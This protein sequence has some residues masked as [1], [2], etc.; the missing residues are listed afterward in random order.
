MTLDELVAMNAGWIL[1]KARSFYHDD[2]NAEDL[3]GETIYRLLRVRDRYDDRLPFRP[4][5]VRI[6][7]N[8]FITDYKRQAVSPI[9]RYE[10][11]DSICGWTEA[12]F[13]A[14]F[15][16]TLGILRRCAAKSVNIEC[17]MLYAKGYTYDEISEMY[18]ISIGTVKSRISNGRTMIRTALG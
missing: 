10:D 15:R 17:V 2:A 11:A 16:S 18:G 7:T 6:M 1:S 3:A 12:D 9:D 4:F 8:L 14:V 5:A 13:R